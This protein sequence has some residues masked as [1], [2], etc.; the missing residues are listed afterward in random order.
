LIFRQDELLDLQKSIADQGVLVPI[1]VYRE[2]SKYILLDGERRWRCAV[3][4]GLARVPAIVQP[5]PGRLQNIMMMFAIH[6]A[7]RDWD[8]LPTAYKLRDLE[9]ILTKQQGKRPTERGLAQVASLKVGEV[10]RLKR[11]L[12][13]PEV[14]RNEL[15]EELKKP[16]SQQVITVDHVI[17][18]TKAATSLRKAAI[19]EPA[20]EDRFH[21]AMLG[22]F[23]TGVLSN[24]VE[25][26][27]LARLS[28]AVRRGEVDRE[29]ASAVVN[30]LVRDDRFGVQQA[31]DESI[32]E[33]DFTH[34]TQQLVERLA[35][36]LG[37]LLERRYRLTAELRK[38][39][40]TVAKR[41][42][43]ILQR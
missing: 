37:D 7:R 22:K 40:E 6:N 3:K 15:M 9:A 19:L 36:Q 14:Y 25:P 21:R 13:L 27:K 11:L 41:I 39:L 12:A 28:R 16:R 42:H 20:A 17:E 8:P 30:R 23:R 29:R 4:L 1:S 38:S 2:G 5:K 26:R 34:A 18:I 10:R 32:A 31:F 35:R 33:S 24:T 43:Q